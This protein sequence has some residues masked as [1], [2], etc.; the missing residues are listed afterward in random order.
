MVDINEN[1]RES[2]VSLDNEV[3]LQVLLTITD[4]NCSKVSG[5]ALMIEG[6]AWPHEGSNNGCLASFISL[7]SPAS[8]WLIFLGGFEES[9]VEWG[10]WLVQGTFL[11]GWLHISKV[12]IVIEVRWVVLAE[13]S[14]SFISSDFVIWCHLKGTNWANLAVILNGANNSG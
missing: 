6:E 5:C 2:F 10:G 8:F 7:Q 4:V 14:E 1:I 13:S 9:C 11:F 12:E 3:K